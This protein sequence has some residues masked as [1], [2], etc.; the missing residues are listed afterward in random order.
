M[1]LV[2]LAAGF[3]NGLLGA[4]G[5]IVLVYGLRAIFAAKRIDVQ[6]IYAMIPVAI[7]PLSALSAWQYFHAGHF[8]GISPLPYLLPAALGGACGAFL[9]RKL[10]TRTLNRIFAA[11]VL[12]S[13]I[14]MVM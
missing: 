9:Q 11:L 14:L 10:Q 12:T 7:L 2:G 13:G 1:P 8:A 5:G 6:G 3:I 4:G